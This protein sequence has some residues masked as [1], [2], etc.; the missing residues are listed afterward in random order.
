MRRLAVVFIL[1]GFVAISC[2]LSVAVCKAGEA[3]F[4]YD[5]GKAKYGHNLYGEALEYLNRALSL[6]PDHL[7]A[8]LLRGRTYFL[9][10]DFDKALADF[11]RTIEINNRFAEGYYW[12]GRTYEEMK[13]TEDAIKDLNK[14][15]E[16]VPDN[17]NYYSSRGIIYFNH[18]DKYGLEQ[19]KKDYRKA[20]E[21]GNL[22]DCLRLQ[23]LTQ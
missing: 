17:P 1:T 5:Q 18:R 21:L 19:V 20:C 6:N 13:R 11:N 15:I 10:I 7:E 22:D 16:L 2:F 14:A 9:L 12:R 4:W 3:D 23:R 8:L